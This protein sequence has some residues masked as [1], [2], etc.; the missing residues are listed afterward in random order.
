M[1][2]D[3]T[4]H[5]SGDLA[6]GQAAS[7]AG[8]G[9]ALLLA[10]P[11]G[12]APDLPTKVVQRYGKLAVSAALEEVQGWTLADALGPD[13][14]DLGGTIATVLMERM[15]AAAEG[16]GRDSPSN[17][18]DR[19]S[20]ELLYA[21]Q[22][23]ATG[24]GGG[25]GGSG[26]S[27][28]QQSFRGE[29]AS[30]P[31]VGLIAAM[32]REVPIVDIVAEKVA[33]Q[34]ESI[35][36][37]PPPQHAPRPPATKPA[38]DA[39]GGGA[40]PRRSQ[41]GRPELY[42]ATGALPPPSE[43]QQAI[44]AKAGPREAQDDGQKAR[45]GKR[46]GSGKGGTS[47]LPPPASP[48]RMSDGSYVSVAP[49]SQ[50]K[51]AC[52]ASA[53]DVSLRPRSA[54]LPNNH[55]GVEGAGG[56]APP[57]AVSSYAPYCETPTVPMPEV[58]D[59]GQADVTD[60]SRLAEDP[61]F[62][63]AVHPVP[64]RLSGA[65]PVLADHFH[66]LAPTEAP[67]PV[68]LVFSLRVT[69]LAKQLDAVKLA[70]LLRLTLNAPM[71]EPLESTLA[72]SKVEAAL[73]DDAKDGG[74]APKIRGGDGALLGLA[75]D[76]PLGPAKILGREVGRAEVQAHVAA[77][78]L[79]RD[80]STNHDGSFEAAAASAEPTG[81]FV[82]WTF[83]PLTSSERTARIAASA[84]RD[85]LAATDQ[86]SLEDTFGVFLTDEAQRHVR[87][88]KAFGTEKDQ[89]HAHFKA[90]YHSGAASAAATGTGEASGSNEA[91]SDG[92]GVAKNDGTGSGSHG[93]A[94]GEQGGDGDGGGSGDGGDGGG[95]SSDGGGGGEVGE[96]SRAATR[97]D[98]S[99]ASSHETFGAALDRQLELQ[100]AAAK[101]ISKCCRGALDRI[102]LRKRRRH[103]VVVQRAV[104]A[105]AL[106]R[107]L[108][109]WPRAARRIQACLRGWRTRVVLRAVLAQAHA[110]RMGLCL[111]AGKVEGWWLSPRKKGRATLQSRTMQAQGSQSAAAPFVVT[112][113]QPKQSSFEIGRPTPEALL[114]ATVERA[115]SH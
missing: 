43:L 11:S 37:P 53:K 114:R 24:G 104:R 115:A 31:L 112:W 33:R 94:G 66:T 80:P 13:G 86:T 46:P 73:T 60:E 92:D 16:R 71:D 62:N 106:R 34:L 108:R 72:K 25:G 52:V 29:G 107:R 65:V 26:S 45:G 68:K 7:Y 20:L 91:R 90:H 32:L 6:A 39:S 40:P 100:G 15:Q 87:R 77:T 27:A 2:K 82:T 70:E 109:A 4:S 1:L 41:M 88:L 110:H 78:P 58:V 64:T 35:G 17:E 96:S 36:P 21:R 103:A 79:S 99:S 54:N 57:T 18:M 3:V 59:Y 113:P 69:Q 101:V 12:H 83:A 5:A 61:A 28:S 47:D 50:S 51:T 93:E 74:A 95:S 89:S 55:G 30:S 63:W 105:Y 49:L 44:W 48:M 19:L 42:A 38:A 9:H 84:A 102:H 56:A 76:V 85:L 14:A 10:A 111:P 8:Q 75:R 67:P 97:C 22:L 81:A 98:S 23:A